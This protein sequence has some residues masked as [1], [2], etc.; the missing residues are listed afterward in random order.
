MVFN[1]T[2]AS[3][4]NGTNFE[5][6]L[7]PRVQSDAVFFPVLPPFSR[8][9]AYDSIHSIFLFSRYGGIQLQNMWSRD[10]EAGSVDQGGRVKRNISGRGDEA[11]E[12]SDQRTSSILEPRPVHFTSTTPES[13][14]PHRV[15]SSPN[16][17]SVLFQTGR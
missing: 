12:F 2:G 10:E 1:G 4:H 6:G 14:E 9:Y 5:R 15:E 8:S 13:I 11:A 7:L 3:N 17:A 16:R